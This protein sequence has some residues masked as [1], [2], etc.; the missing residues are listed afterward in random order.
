LYLVKD[1]SIIEP[2]YTIELSDDEIVH[3][4]VFQNIKLW[5]IPSQALLEQNLP[6]LLPLVPL[7]REGDRREVLEQ[8]VCRLQQADQKALLEIGYRIAYRM[9]KE[10]DRQWLKEMFMND[11]YEDYTD[12]D[13]AWMIEAIREKVSKKILEQGVKQGLEQGV[14][15]GLEQ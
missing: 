11:R 14:K 7:T 8:M 12:E 4:F 1:S 6:Y 15:Q 10:I 13:D 9:L 5:E 3:H 2:P